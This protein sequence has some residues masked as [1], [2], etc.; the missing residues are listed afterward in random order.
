ARGQSQPALLRGKGKPEARARRLAL[1]GCLDRAFDFPLLIH[2]SPSQ[3]R[4]DSHWEPFMEAFSASLGPLPDARGRGDSPA[5]RGSPCPGPTMNGR[6]RASSKCGEL[7]A[8]WQRTHTFIG[9][10]AEMCPGGSFACS[11][12]GPWHISH[13]TS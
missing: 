13:W 10:S 3:S 2:A 11:L 8:S 5:A 6:Y 9:A 4:Q 7:A 1:G 12:A